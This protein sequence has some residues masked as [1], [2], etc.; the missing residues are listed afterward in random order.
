MVPHFRRASFASQYSAM[1]ARCCFWMDRATHR[2]ATHDISD[3]V[4]AYRLAATFCFAAA[5]WTRQQDRTNR[6]QAT[7]R[8]SLSCLHCFLLAV[9]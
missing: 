3:G 2:T 8:F 5:K 6:M 7:A 1:V 9:A 4:E